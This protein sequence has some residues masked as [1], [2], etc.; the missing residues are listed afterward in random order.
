MLRICFFFKFSTTLLLVIFINVLKNTLKLCLFL[1][2]T[3]PTSITK[4]NKST[5][6]CNSDGGTCDCSTGNIM[7]IDVS[8]GKLQGTIHPNSYIFSLLHLQKLIL[9][10]NTFNG[11]QIPSKI[12]RFSNSLTH[13]NLYLCSFICKV[14]PDITL[15]HKLVS[16]K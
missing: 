16:Y 9:A 11:S 2:K 1:N 10:Y 6:C 5:D 3:F 4:M 12:G 7:S 14:P 15:L 13:L 8:C